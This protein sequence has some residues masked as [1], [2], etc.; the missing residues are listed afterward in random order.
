M[1]NES[2]YTLNTVLCFIEFLVHNG[3][4]YGSIMNYV[5]GIRS[6]FRWF[7]ITDKHFDNVRVSLLLKAV[8]TTVRPVPKFKGLFTSDDL[9][10][11]I[12]VT[13]TMPLASIFKTIYLFA[14]FGFFRISNLVATTCS[15]FD[16]SKQLCRADVVV[17]EAYLIILVKWSKTLQQ[18]RQGSYIMLPRLLGSN[19][20][21]WQAYRQMSQSEP[22]GANAPLFVCN[23]TPITQSQVRAHLSKVNRV[24]GL[25]PTTHTFHTFRR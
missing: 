13:S 3:L 25:D 4:Q 1:Q 15:D 7:Q 18:S 16:A 23:G 2:N 24:L 17:N 10:R 5:S 6:I 11:I 9:K 20:C 14:F 8:A 19:I 22:S 12:C 21:P